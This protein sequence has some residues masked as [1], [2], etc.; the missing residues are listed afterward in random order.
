MHHDIKETLNVNFPKLYV[1]G[2]KIDENSKRRQHFARFGVSLDAFGFLNAGCMSTTATADMQRGR[3]IF[4]AA[5]NEE[6]RY[7]EQ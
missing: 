2:P 4:H 1:R 3:V 5:S 7:L 6:C